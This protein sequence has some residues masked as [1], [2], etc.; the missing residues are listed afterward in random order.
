MS[1]NHKRLIRENIAPKGA[2]YVGIVKDG[3]VVGRIPIKGTTLEH[4]YGK[5]LY[6]FAVMS[7]IHLS[8]WDFPD[9][10]IDI[11]VEKEED[12]PNIRTP[13]YIRAR[14]LEDFQTAL[15][16]IN[17]GTDAEMICACGDLGAWGFDLELKLYAKAAG[18]DYH[19]EGQFTGSTYNKL[20]IYT[21]LGNHELRTGIRGTSSKL[22][23]IDDGTLYDTAT[24]PDV[25][26]KYTGMDSYNKVIDYNGDHFIFFSLNC[27]G[28]IA[29]QGAMDFSEAD[30]QWI[31][32]Q[33]DKYKE[34]RC[35]IFTHCFF[36]PYGAGDFGDVYTAKLWDGDDKFKNLRKNYKNTV[37]FSG[38]SHWHWE[39][40]G[41]KNKWCDQNGIKK[42]MN[43]DA[44]VYPCDGNRKEEGWAVHVPSCGDPR[45]STDD[46]RQYGDGNNMPYDAQGNNSQF[47]L[48]DVYSEGI[49]I[50]GISLEGQITK[51]NK[52]LE[53]EVIKKGEYKRKPIGTYFLKIK[54]GNEPEEL[55]IVGEVGENNVITLT[56]DVPDDYTLCYLDENETE[57]TDFERFDMFQNA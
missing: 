22:K 29:S 3:Q 33:L 10:K 21:C 43:R 39:M 53:T 50:N 41:Q 47:A 17:K 42:G 48:I 14:D 46:T 51:V 57:L 40:Q 8:S 25:W 44:N 1:N 15:E 49:V 56:D 36:Y 6:S 20:P 35:F 16:Y 4:N 28:F 9:K 18:F 24:N 19:N 13:F 23:T 27:G 26:K 30:Y 32:S 31:E 54:G 37:W 52:D 5:K 45:N 2:K 7:D 38:H 34:D 11:K 12:R 55:P